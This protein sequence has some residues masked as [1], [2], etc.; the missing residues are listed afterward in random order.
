VNYVYRRNEPPVA[1]PEH[2]GSDLQRSKPRK[3]FDPELCG[4][5]KGYQQHRRHEQEQCLECKQAHSKYVWATYK[6]RA[7]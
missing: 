3:P 7:K 1:Q 4:T 5:Q 2:D 6:N